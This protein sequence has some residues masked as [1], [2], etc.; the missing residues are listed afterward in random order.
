MLLLY[1]NYLKVILKPLSPQ[2]A[3]PDKGGDRLR[4][5][6]AARERQLHDIFPHGSSIRSDGQTP[7]EASKRILYSVERI[8]SC[9]MLSA[10][11]HLKD[12]SRNLYPLLF[13][14]EPGG[15]PCDRRS[16]GSKGR[17]CWNRSLTLDNSNEVTGRHIITHALINSVP[18]V[19]VPFLQRFCFIRNGDVEF[20]HFAAQIL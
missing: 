9:R 8:S 4:Y 3:P 1:H 11:Y 7:V 6:R 20:V 19:A 18:K 16:I 5:A 12:G 17:R 15:A 2:F 14:Y 10:L 13:G